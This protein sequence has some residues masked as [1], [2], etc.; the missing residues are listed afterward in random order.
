MKLLKMFYFICQYI[1]SHYETCEQFTRYNNSDCLYDHQ[2]Y[3]KYCKQ[4]WK[5]QTVDP[6]KFCQ[7]G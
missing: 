7:K 3:M 5:K 2:I 6:L 1:L 4:T